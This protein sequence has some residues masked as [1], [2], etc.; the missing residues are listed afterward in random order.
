[1]VLTLCEKNAFWLSCLWSSLQWNFKTAY[2]ED[3]IQRENLSDICK[4]KKTKKNALP[5][6]SPINLYITVQKP[7]N[8]TLKHNEGKFSSWEDDALS[9][10]QNNTSAQSEKLKLYL[11]VPG[12][13]WKGTSK[14]AYAKAGVPKLF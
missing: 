9:C 12:Y 10:N 4:N 5:A 1:M 8:Q 6:V 14:A 13:G 3:Y 7:Y 11:L 2:S